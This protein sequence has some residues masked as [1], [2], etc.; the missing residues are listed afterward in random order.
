MKEK[1]VGDKRKV[2]SQILEDLVNCYKDLDFP[3]SEVES[4]WEIMKKGHDRV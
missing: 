2:R 1:V 4:H 3:W